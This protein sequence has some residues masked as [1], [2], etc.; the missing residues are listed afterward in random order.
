MEV[1]IDQ[2]HKEWDLEYI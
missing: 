1:P 2:L